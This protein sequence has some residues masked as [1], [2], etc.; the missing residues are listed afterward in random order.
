MA[1][2]FIR[3]EYH[4]LASHALRDET[5]GSLYVIF[6]IRKTKQPCTCLTHLKRTQPRGHFAKSE[7][8]WEIED[9]LNM[10][11]NRW[12]TIDEIH[13]EIDNLLVG[14]NV[15]YELDTEKYNIQM[16]GWRGGWAI[17][18]R[19]TCSGFDSRPDLGE[20][21]PMASPEGEARGSVRLLLAK[22]HPVSTPVF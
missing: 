1:L 3:G 12:K 5:R 4:P 16:H 19:A 13:W 20:N 21:L 8:T 17:G 2:F 7:V 18:Y 22:N 11:Q 10:L 15:D 6:D 14:S 9:K